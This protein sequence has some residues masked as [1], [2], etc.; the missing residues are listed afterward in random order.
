ML[1][2]LFSADKL[3]AESVMGHKYHY[4]LPISFHGWRG[5]ARGVDRGGTYI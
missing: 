3:V 5:V 2:Q 4:N 1:V